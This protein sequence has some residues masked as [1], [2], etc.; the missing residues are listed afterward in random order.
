MA[1]C[2]AAGLEGI[3]KKLTV[4]KPTSKNLF[5]SSDSD[6]RKEN[7]EILPQSLKEAIDEMKKDKFIKE[8]LGQ[9]IF[10]KYI[11]ILTD[12]IKLCIKIHQYDVYKTK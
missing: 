11:M 5:E 2:L 8:I 1:I 10:E 7:V 12:K 6:L 9:H 3:K 4:P